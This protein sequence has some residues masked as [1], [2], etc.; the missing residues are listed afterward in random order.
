MKHNTSI[1]RGTYMQVSNS[2]EEKDDEKG[3]HF[4]PKRKF[5]DVCRHQELKQRRQYDVPACNHLGEN[6]VGLFSAFALRSPFR[7]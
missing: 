2:C 6:T 4:L 7:G 5:Q 1:C 3:L